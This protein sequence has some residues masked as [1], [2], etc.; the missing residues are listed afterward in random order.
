MFFP[1]NEFS[2]RLNAKVASQL[3]SDDLKKHRTGLSDVQLSQHPSRHQAD[4][5][6]GRFLPERICRICAEGGRAFCRQT[7]VQRDCWLQL[8]KDSKIFL[9]PLGKNTTEYQQ[10]H[11]LCLVGNRF[12]NGIERAPGS[13]KKSLK[14]YQSSNGSS[15]SSLTED[16]CLGKRSSE[17]MAFA[18]FSDL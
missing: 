4:S 2:S 6:L 18:N 8:V 7:L 5:G 15:S 17:P 16:R 1:G 14:N 12:E 13:S 9:A 10:L 11:S 3:N